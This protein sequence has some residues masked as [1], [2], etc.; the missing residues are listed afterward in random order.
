MIMKSEQ[1][2]Y[3]F[4]CGVYGAVGVS[5]GCWL[6]NQPPSMAAWVAVGGGFVG[7]FL[8]GLLRAR[9]LSVSERQFDFPH[10]R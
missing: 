8:G 1:I 10:I 2:V 5:L 6:F 9:R 3:A 7:A 4:R